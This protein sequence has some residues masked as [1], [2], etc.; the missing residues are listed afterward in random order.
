MAKRGN[1]GIPKKASAGTC[2]SVLER[3]IAKIAAYWG[4]RKRTWLDE[5]AQ[6]FDELVEPFTY[7][8]LDVTDCE[9]RAVNLCFTEW[10]LF[11]RPMHDNKT[12]LELYIERQPSG[13]SADALDRLQQVAATQFFSRF[14]IAGKDRES[15]M[16]VLRDMRTGERYNVH[17][18][19]LCKVDRWRDGVIALRI[20]QVDGL[21]Q[22]ISATHL[23]DIASPRKTAVDG[24]GAVH[25]E[26]RK[27]APHTAS[28]SFYLRFL[29]DV[30][31]ADGRYTSTVR[32]RDV[33]R[34]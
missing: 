16:A 3:D 24:P 29:R 9:V 1:Q 8:M 6:T 31:G 28:M 30:I 2:G 4:E 7:H 27:R 34:A 23:Y 22:A 32:L 33:S 18:P 10:V 5:A 21:W 15:G 19:L 11:E 13:I 12:P 20:A 17:D 14:A 25:P 26:D